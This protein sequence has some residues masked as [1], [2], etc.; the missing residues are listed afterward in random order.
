[1]DT[2]E[3]KQSVSGARRLWPVGNGRN[4]R[5]AGAAGQAGPLDGLDEP[6]LALAHAV[7]RAGTPS[8]E[9]A[10]VTV[11]Q[12]AV[13]RLRAGTVDVHAGLAGAVL[14]KDAHLERSGAGIVAGAKVQL[15]R[16]GAQWLIGGLVQARQ[17]F[18]ITVI[19]ARVEGQVKCLFDTR[20]AFAF[21]AGIALTSALLRVLVFRRR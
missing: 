1:M 9:A 14:A 12:G 3:G 2:A 4:G 10:A 16:G 18:A 15:D 8:V 21:G 19:A 7:R 20:G 17:V 13:G 5:H 11:E 6:T